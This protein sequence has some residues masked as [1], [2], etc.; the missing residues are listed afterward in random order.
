MN[1]HSVTT[2]AVTSTLSTEPVEKREAILDA[3]LELFA[4]RTFDGTPVPLIEER[5][6][7]EDLHADVFNLAADCAENRP[8]VALLEA[9]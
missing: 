2:N 6:G 4:Q 1:I 5:A 9:V 3:A 8:R 7:V